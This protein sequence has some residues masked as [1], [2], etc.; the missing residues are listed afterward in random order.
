MSKPI[1]SAKI[2]TS[3]QVS[4]PQDIRKHLKAEIGDLLLF[5]INNEGEVVIKTTV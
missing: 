4:I 2:T 5:F 3:Y 1:A